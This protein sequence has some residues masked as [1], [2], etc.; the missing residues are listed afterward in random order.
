MRNNIIKIGIISLFIVAFCTACN[1]TITR[2]IRHAGFSVSSKFVCEGFFPESKEDT[3]YKKIRYITANHLIDQDGKIYEI[4]LGQSFANNQ[5]CKISTAGFTLKAILDDNI[6][7]GTDNKYYY[8]NGQN[9]VAP[10]TEIPETDNSYEIYDLL[11]KEPDVVKVITADSSIGKYYLL[12]TDGNVYSYVISRTERDKPAAITSISRVY[13][14]ELY[15][16][17]II[18]FNYAGD[19]L[20]TFVKTDFKIVRMQITNIDKC[21]KYADISCEFNM[22]EDMMFEEN[23]DYIIAYNGD[24]LITNYGQV[25]TMSN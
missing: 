21:K 11:L 4:S 19:S 8:L 24:L 22:K 25:F 6:A 20:T 16:A 14:K 2:N 3:S 10:Y 15:G 13:E 12:K 5:N 1:G 9:N 7:K 23:K 17:N 18:D